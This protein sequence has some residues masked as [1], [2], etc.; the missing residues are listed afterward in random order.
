VPPCLINSELSPTFRKL[1]AN[2]QKSYPHVGD[3]LKELFDSVAQDYRG[4]KGARSVPHFED[5]I[6]K[7]RQNSS[8][9]KRGA[10]YGFRVIAYFSAGTLYP[11]IVYAK[12][13]LSDVSDRQIELALQEIEVLLRLRE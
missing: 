13:Q 8:D 5:R 2:L 7:Y 12:P 9:I 3:D 4:A 11:I 10:R 1:L 6:W